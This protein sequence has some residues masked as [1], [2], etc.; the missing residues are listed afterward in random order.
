MKYSLYRLAIA[1]SALCGI[2]ILSTSLAQSARADNDDSFEEV[3]VVAN[4]AP[5]PLSKI[6]N[7]VTVLDAAAIKA[8]Q[9]PGVADLLAQTPGVTFARTGG[10]GQPTSVFIRG[11]ESTQ[12]VVVIDGVQLND[13]STT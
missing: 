7:S 6:G 13:P 3:V 4:R 8:S 1:A 2:A 10:L 5:E 9:E 12:T 11:A